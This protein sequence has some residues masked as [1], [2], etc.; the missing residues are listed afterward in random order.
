M[1]SGHGSISFLPQVF[2]PMFCSLMQSQD[3]T[4]KAPVKVP[5]RHVLRSLGKKI[6]DAFDMLI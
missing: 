1:V 3:M 5:K 4:S 2:W 6:N